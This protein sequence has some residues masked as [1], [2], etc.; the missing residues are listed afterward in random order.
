VLRKP[1]QQVSVYE[2]R[3]K[4]AAKAAPAPAADSTVH[5]RQADRDSGDDDPADPA[6]DVLL[7]SLAVRKRYGDCSDMWLH[8]RLGDDSGFPRPIYIAGVRHWRLSDLLRWE[9]AQAELPAPKPRVLEHRDAAMVA[10]AEK[11]AEQK[12]R[13]VAQAE[14]AHGS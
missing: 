7:R 13:K 9:R 6:A 1:S 4:S 3:L 14:T 12:R 10:L 11:R 5:G 8:R 2:K